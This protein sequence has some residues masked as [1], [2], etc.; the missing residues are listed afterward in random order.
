MWMGKILVSGRRH[1]RLRNHPREGEVWFPW[2]QIFSLVML[3][4]RPG[5]FAGPRWTL[6]RKRLSFKHD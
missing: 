1:R 4:A 2:V 5:P 3:L 6:D